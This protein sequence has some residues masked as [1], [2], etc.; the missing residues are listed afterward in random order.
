MPLLHCTKCHHEWE[1]DKCDMCD[2]CGAHGKV[3]A[4]ETQFEAFLKSDFW[5]ELSKKVVK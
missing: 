1:G 3:I 5:K 2:W 4:E